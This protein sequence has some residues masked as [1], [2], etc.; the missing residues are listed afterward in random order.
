MC[1]PQTH[2]FEEP[3]LPSRRGL[4]AVPPDGRQKRLFHSPD[5]TRYT[6]P[7]LQ[8]TPA[9]ADKEKI[10]A[11]YKERDRLAK[12]T[13]HPHDVDHEIPLQHPLVSG[14]NVHNNLRPIRRS[15]NES[16]N[17]YFPHPDQLDLPL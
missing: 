12:E 6:L 10:A 1:G 15:L 13:G 17:N 7:L 14:L 8:R 3:L 4:R 2:L 11:V 5:Y 16:K 9:W